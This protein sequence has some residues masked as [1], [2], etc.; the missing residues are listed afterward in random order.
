MEISKS[1][2]N[3]SSSGTGSVRGSFFKETPQHNLKRNSS[4]SLLRKTSSNRSS[5]RTS[6]RT[7]GR[8]S[9][10]KYR[11]S[12]KSSDKQHLLKF[13]P[14]NE[15]QISELKSIVKKFDTAKLEGE[16][17]RNNDIF[18]KKRMEEVK[19]LEDKIKED[20][21]ILLR[22][23]QLKKLH[24][25]FY[26][27]Y[28]KETRIVDSIN[29]RYFNNRKLRQHEKLR[30]KY[31]S[32][33]INLQNEQDTLKNKIKRDGITKNKLLYDVTTLN[34]IM[35]ELNDDPTNKNFRYYNDNFFEKKYN[36]SMRNS[37]GSRHTRKRKY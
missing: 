10:R 17:K 30:N 7:S 34:N 37:G 6:G 36:K 31:H 11:D 29:P 22:D 19:K 16:I 20:T 2:S 35:N 9:S 5:A 12:R 33:V 28:D 26:N 3:R 1:I 4:S 15:K 14:E 24:E 32:I 25:H 23:Q 21:K 8:T 18:D 27:L 13:I